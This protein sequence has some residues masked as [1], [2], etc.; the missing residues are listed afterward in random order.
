MISLTTRNYNRTLLLTI[1]NTYYAIRNIRKTKT[2]CASSRTSR[3]CT[4]KK[5]EGPVNHSTDNRKIL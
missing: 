5:N 4:G 1:S 2:I 3:F